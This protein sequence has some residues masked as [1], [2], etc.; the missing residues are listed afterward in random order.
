MNHWHFVGVFCSFKNVK[1]KNVI[2]KKMGGKPLLYTRIL[3]FLY[4]RE[5]RIRIVRVRPSSKFM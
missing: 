5:L 2:K 3:L 4:V 1:K